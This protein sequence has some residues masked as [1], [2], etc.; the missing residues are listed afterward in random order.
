MSEENVELAR[1]LYPER[2]DLAATFADSEALEAV[3]AAFKPLVH[4]EF[5]IV[6]DPR[7]QMLLGEPGEQLTVFF[8]IDG[9]VS[10]FREWFSEW[11]SW[12]V[13]PTDFIDV[14]D[15]RVLVVAEISGRSK[16][17][18]IDMTVQGG[19]VL[20]FGDGRLTRLELFFRRADA[21]EAAGLSE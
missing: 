7:Y 2:M 14:D 20:T 17:Q 4:P 10:A 19:N 21:L 9:F 11:E 5:E 3:Q 13:T 6:A 12:V 8:G 16:A 1:R 18:Q 15:N